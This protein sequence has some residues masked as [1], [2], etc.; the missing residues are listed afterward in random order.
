MM[1]LK[2]ALFLNTFVWLKKERILEISL[3]LLYMMILKGTPLKKKLK[4]EYLKHAWTFLT[5]FLSLLIFFLIFLQ[6]YVKT[7]RI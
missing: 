5:F 7:P 6:K 4:G 3:A 1:I 2:G